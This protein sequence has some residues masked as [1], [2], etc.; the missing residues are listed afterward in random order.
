MLK[1]NEKIH[2]FVVKRV[3][4]VPEIKATLVEMRHEGC[5]AR[6]TF[7]DREDENKTFSI[8][9][10]TIPTDDTGVFHIIEHSVLCGSEKYTVKEPFVELLKKSLNTFLNAMTFPDKTMYPISSRNDKD[11]LNLVSVY[12]DAVLNPAILH[13][14]NIFLQEGWHY[15]LDTK[16]GELKTSGVVLNEMRG[17]YSAPESLG[18]Y[19]MAALMYPDTCY[20][21]ESGGKPEAITDLTYEDFVAAHKKF[22]HPTTAEIFL[23]GSVDLDKTLA[24]ISSYL[25]GYGKQPLDIDIQDRPMTKPAKKTVEY[26]IAPNEDKTNKTRMLLGFASHRFDEKVKGM[27]VSVILD[28][29]CSSNESPLKKALLASGL[30]EDVLIT[31]YDSLKDNMIVMEF[32]NV[33]DGK[34]EQL[35]NLFYSEARR[36]VEE[37]IDRELLTA[38]LNSYEFK[39]REK[40]FGRLPKGLAY[41]ITILESTLYGQDAVEALAYEKNFKALREGLETDYYEKLLLSVF[42]ENESRAAVI[43]NPSATLGKERA[44]KERERLAKIKA[45][46]SDEELERII[47][48]NKD[49]KQWQQTPDTPQAMATIPTLDLTDVSDKA[50]VLAEDVL[51]V[52]ETTVLS[53]KIATDG[54]EY[55]ELH[56]DVSDLDEG[57]FFDLRILLAL[58]GNVA[59]EKRTALELQNLIKKE[60]GSFDVRMSAFTREKEAK[61]YVV[62]ETSALNPKRSSIVDIV[63][64]VLYSSV[65]SD[66]ELMKNI[67]RQLKMGAEDSFISAGHAAG[68]GRCSAYVCSEGAILEYYSG[69]ESYVKIK[70]LEKNFDSDAD[71][72]IEKISALAKRI[73]T[74]ERLT[75]SVT[76]DFDK[77]HAESLVE[78][79]IPGGEYRSSS[80]I[81]PLGVRREGIVIP[82]E[83]AYA[84]MGSNLELYGENRCG[85]LLV[86]RSILS[87]AYL[88]NA[89]RVQGGAYGTG[90]IVGAGGSICYYSYRDP[91]PA[92]SV[93][94]YKSASEFLRSFADTES[95]I[96]G[97]II[98][99]VGDA[100]PLLTPRMKGSSAAANYLRGVS[101]EKRCKTRKE[102]LE[103]DAN[104][105]KRIAD[106]LDKVAKTDA[107]CI[108]GGKEK[109]DACAEI[110]DTVLEI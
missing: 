95:D 2:G 78:A 88:W 36:I 31:P 57:D 40:D 26:E 30:C 105:L 106:I 29:I 51:T 77:N 72:L 12:M 15:E 81:S 94:I 63:S 80:N 83:V 27:A 76:G 101:Y 41:A 92:R 11:F 53:H 96:S 100:N 87:Y 19:H 64:E 62:V 10:K 59:T 32:R 24:L 82:S 93:G 107:I 34:C 98:G 68:Y 6:L 73:F 52:S 48:Q 4:E 65:Y 89:V 99:A 110:I 42:V 91:S 5:D 75:L 61:A 21:C 69:Y 44:E 25:E 74:R 47:K 43:M 8:A 9:F 67:V 84:E 39:I 14:P 46:L 108:V 86:A 49:L 33:K 35:E 102:M 55:D 97:F 70:K 58:I 28:A 1:I 103:T 17:A 13:T 56:F 3:L 71:C 66:K 60:L 18:M 37:G 45:S 104:E 16:D 85:S 38:S 54:I 22:Y 23:D 50:E 20:A 109:L 90:L 7:L 79:I